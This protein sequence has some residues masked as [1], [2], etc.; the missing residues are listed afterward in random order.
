[1]LNSHATCWGHETARALLLWTAFI[2]ATTNHGYVFVTY[3]LY[4]N[5]TRPD[6]AAKAWLLVDYYL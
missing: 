2:V 6:L 4:E 3:Y 1:M 5:H